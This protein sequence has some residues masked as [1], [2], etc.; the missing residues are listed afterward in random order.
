M[1]SELTTTQ[2]IG[3]ILFVIGVYG[4]WVFAKT[5]FAPLCS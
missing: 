3:T 2:V 4:G 5:I 1:K